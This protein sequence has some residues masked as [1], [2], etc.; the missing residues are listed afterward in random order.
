[1]TQLQEIRLESLNDGPGLLPF[2][3]GSM[4]LTT[5]YHTFIQYVKLDD[6]ETNIHSLQTQLLDFR[7]RMSNETYNLY[8]IQI[9]YLANKLGNVLKQLHSLEPSGINRMKRGLIDGL[10]SM[11]KS[12][13]GNLDHDDALKYNEAIR[14]LENNQI[15]LSS[16]FN[17]HIS[18]SKE[19]MLKHGNVIRQIVDNQNRIN[20]TLELILQNKAIQS[21][22]RYANF[23]Q[24]LSLISENIEDLSLEL[25]R[26]E[27]SLAFIHASSTHHSMIDIDV[28]E[29]M[30]LKLKSIYSEEQVLD[31]DLR[32]YYNVIKPGS[33]FVNKQIVFIFKFPIY[34][35][36]TY[37]FY[38]LSVVPNKHDQAL[39][40]PFPFLATIEM[41]FVYMEAECPKLKNWYL[42]EIGIHHQLHTKSDCIHELIT[43]QALQESCEFTT[44][45]LTR[46]AM[47][48]LDDQHYVLSFPRQ[49]KAQLICNQK[50]Y[51]LL[52]GSYLATIP[53]GCRFKSEQFTI[54]N[55]Y[56]EI[57]G[58]P[59]KFMKIPYN[60]EK[61]AT[62]AIH[63]NLKTIDLQGLHNIQDQLMIQTPI[64]IDE[65]RENTLYHTTIP[66]YSILLSAGVL[67]IIV[68][69][70]RYLWK[71][72]DVKRK[73]QP[74]PEI[75][76]T[77]SNPDN[78]PATFSLNVLK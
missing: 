51:T 37:D 59:L 57:K 11:I 41:S 44:V 1:M 48:K 73:Q 23:A 4:K 55:D 17:N 16:E 47:E 20:K 24:L 10:G 67:G 77:S 21:L 38:R 49:T 65:V 64:Q 19:W 9:N 34:S 15:K 53:V 5:H 42:C 72:N 3:L 14:V 69:T 74:S 40:P 30:I 50:D 78:I 28:L 60:S 12:L 52:Q 63:V 27:N 62:K 33:Y 58:Q 70:R 75:L 29:S 43:N 31:L 61:Q 35:K 36:I 45:T 8:E 68:A 56:N 46:E 76:Q 13:T 39:I 18:L 2:K 7:N 32:E 26:I 54:V 25:L 6:L 66:F 22:T 71:R